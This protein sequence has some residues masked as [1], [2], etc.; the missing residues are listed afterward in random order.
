MMRENGKKIIMN[1]A[2]RKRLEEN[3]SLTTYELQSREMDFICALRR[4]ILNC[5][6]VPVMAV[7]L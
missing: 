5:S 1:L 7:G 6:L 3:S 2:G 4:C